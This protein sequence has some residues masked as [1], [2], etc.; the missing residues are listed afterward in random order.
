[1][2]KRSE[3]C[4]LMHSRMVTAVATTSAQRHA[5]RSVRTRVTSASC[6]LACGSSNSIRCAGATT[7]SLT[8]DD[9]I[10]PETVF[11]FDL[12]EFRRCYWKAALFKA[13]RHAGLGQRR[14]ARLHPGI[15]KRLVIRWRI[16]LGEV[17]PRRRQ[18]LLALEQCLVVGF[19]FVAPLSGFL[20]GPGCARMNRNHPVLGLAVGRKAARA[21]RGI[22]VSVVARDHR[23]GDGIDLVCAQRAVRYEDRIGVVGELDRLVLGD[24][25]PA[26]RDVRKEERAN[27]LHTLPAGL[28]ARGQRRP[29]DAARRR[30]EFLCRASDGGG[31]GGID[32]V[33]DHALPHR[34]IAREL[35]NLDVALLEV[36]ERQDR[37]R[38][39][40]QRR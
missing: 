38:V 9:I 2:K 13:V 16:G 36:A 5:P 33:V 27:L 37:E 15:E 25:G 8:E 26:G 4:W 34:A 20:Q 17:R 12:S 23:L 29:D 11:A 10:Y 24:A 39:L 32:V 21:W 35:D 18:Y 28:V 7:L 22:L 40:V 31:E 6:M 3:N 19:L 1:M 30:L 14:S